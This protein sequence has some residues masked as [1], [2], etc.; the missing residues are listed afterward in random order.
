[1]M[2]EVSSFSSKTHRVQNENL[3]SQRR[4]RIRVVRCQQ[5]SAQE[6][7]KWSHNVVA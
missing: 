2:W 5:M 1:M 6:K 7:E 3:E 4:E